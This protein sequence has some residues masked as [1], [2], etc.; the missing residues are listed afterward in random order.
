MTK[1]FIYL[2]T[3]LAMLFGA[4]SIT[5]PVHA[6][7]FETW[8]TGPAS[9][10]GET[11]F[12]VKIEFED[13][14]DYCDAGNINDD[15]CFKIGDIVVENG[16]IV[17]FDD[18]ELFDGTINDSFKWWIEIEPDGEM[19]VTIS[20][21]PYV[22]DNGTGVGDDYN[23]AGEL[24][25]PFV[26]VGQFATTLTWAYNRSGS[27]IPEYPEGMYH[28]GYGWFDIT[29][30]FEKTIEGL[31]FDDSKVLVDDHAWF[32]IIPDPNFGGG[33][34]LAS[35]TIRVYPTKD[36]DIA[37]QVEEEAAKALVG[38]E[39][40]AESNVM[41]VQYLGEIGTYEHLFWKNDPDK[42]LLL[43]PYYGGL[44]DL[45]HANPDDKDR[46]PGIPGYTFGYDQMFAVQPMDAVY[47]DFCGEEVVSYVRVRIEAQ[48]T[49]PGDDRSNW[50]EGAFAVAIYQDTLNGVEDPGKKLLGYGANNSMGVIDIVAEIPAG[51][52][53]GVVLAEVGNFMIDTDDWTEYLD[54]WIT[55]GDEPGGGVL[56][57]FRYDADYES[58]AR[59]IQFSTETSAYWVEESFPYT[60]A[61]IAWG[62]AQYWA[63]IPAGDYTVGMQQA[64][65]VRPDQPLPAPQALS[66]QARPERRNN[67]VYYAGEVAIPELAYYEWTPQEEAT[68]EATTEVECGPTGLLMNV[69][70]N[71]VEGF[72]FDDL[73][74][75][76]LQS[77]CPWKWDEGDLCSDSVLT[78]Y[79]NPGYNWDLA[80]SADGEV[81]NWLLV[82][83][84]FNVGADDLHFDLC[85][86]GV[87]YVEQWTD[88]DWDFAELQ[89]GMPGGNLTGR[90]FISVYNYN[91][92]IVN[93]GYDPDEKGK[94]VAEKVFMLAKAGCCG[95][96][97]PFIPKVTLANLD[98]EF[99]DCVGPYVDE[100]CCDTDV[101]ACDV[102]EQK[103]FGIKDD[104][105]Y[106]DSQNARIRHQA[107]MEWGVGFDCEVVE[108]ETC[109]PPIWYYEFEPT[110][111][112]WDF[113]LVDVSDCMELCEYDCLEP[114]YAF[115]VGDGPFQSEAGVNAPGEFS[116]AD[117]GTEVEL[118]RDKWTD[119][120]G[121]KIL[122]IYYIADCTNLCVEE[123]EA[124]GWEPDF[125][126]PVFEHVV[127]EYKVIEAVTGDVV[128]EA[129]D[130]DV[131]SLGP[132]TE[133][134][135]YKYMWTLEHGYLGDI[136]GHE[137][138]TEKVCCVDEDPCDC[139]CEEGFEFTN[140]DYV[141]VDGGY[142]LFAISPD[143]ARMSSEW[144]WAWIEA[145]YELDLTVG[146]DAENYGPS[147]TVNRA[148]MAVFMS[149]VLQ[150]YGLMP[151]GD[152]VDFADVP[153]DHWAAAGIAHVQELG[154]T[155]GCGDGNFC[156]MD[157]VTRAQM[158]I[159]IERTFRAVKTAG[160]N[161][162]W[163][164]E[165]LEILAPGNSFVDVPLD[166]WANVW[167][168][169]LLAD[170]LTSGCGDGTTFCP[171]EPVTRRQ[172]ARFIIG[173][174]L[175]SDEV[176]DF[177][178][179][180][181]P[182]LE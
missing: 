6:E 123:C 120:F 98:Q 79:Y 80:I 133:I 89:L 46:F 67:W 55:Q 68:I 104:V 65:D 13:Q 63:D 113:A 132:V 112:E 75:G 49:D 125:I 103:W 158:A 47:T 131:T 84:A 130:W 54:S 92:F 71:V 62:A 18:D 111:A 14:A 41:Y 129:A 91:E 33:E 106:T 180:L 99:K 110:E 15:T 37:I 134:G 114:A 176:K 101:V 144:A 157:P 105:W 57:D 147:M 136:I 2:C 90:T 24:V 85:E 83:L 138:I 137:D 44:I 152:P 171:T 145:M 72:L 50:V 11:N 163:W 161:D 96:P 154:I 48:E 173:A 64:G 146:V 10:D 93:E 117:L 30:T 26:E 143:D 60:D 156:P 77:E 87:Q 178:P 159:F 73:H 9:H 53:Y 142:Q 42:R 58:D 5:T 31:T 52:T 116:V 141:K 170:G 167:I 12:I 25:V 43:T 39:M 122:D 127:P 115:I 1:K 165:D 59:A 168:E 29:L 3:V 97:G 119:A 34:D 175:T 22:T 126:L 160:L 36:E 94:Y 56:V 61:W 135:R 82:S 140:R 69:F 4:L 81:S 40:S 20:I 35:Y 100:V 169:E 8:I 95:E 23:L 149:K 7:D 45:E 182:E 124:C 148:Q 38:D 70:L 174:M 150:E 108:G 177:W 102:F 107:F 164:D 166:H 76:S 179:S 16:T 51:A 27:Y 118:L 151:S 66:G 139:D 19:D 162:F 21:E 172:M 28:D 74:P 155:G 86:T 32:E 181:A 153:A 17:D 121:N 88:K 78:F 109:F 128:V